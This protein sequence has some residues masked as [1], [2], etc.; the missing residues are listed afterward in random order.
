[1]PTDAKPDPVEVAASDLSRRGFV[2]TAT[3]VAASGLSLAPAPARTTQ[4]DMTSLPPYGNGTL[5]PSIRSRIIAGV[6]GMNVH[7]LEAGFET[8]GRPA[9]L[10]LHGFPELAYSWRKVMPTLAAA[11]YHV[12]A[13]DQRGYGRTSGWDDSSDAEADPF[14]ILNM[15][16]D[17]MSL[18]LALGYREVAAV[19]GHDAGSPVVAWSA[20]IRPDMF[21]SV[22]L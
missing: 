19:V 7:I 13:P 16:R 11:G 4:V 15:G 10:L 17:A 12:I 1:M 18:V 14:P 2:A 20:L 21:R 22:V 6:N 5:P 9:L 3:A 8:P